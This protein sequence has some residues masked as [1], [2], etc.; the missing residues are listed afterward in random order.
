VIAYAG[1]A[2]SYNAEITPGLLERGIEI[3]EQLGLE[4]EW[5]LSPSYVLG[6]RLARMG[7]TDRARSVLEQFEAQAHERGDEVSRVLALWP[8]ALVEWL[9]GRWQRA[10]GHATAA[11]ELTAQTQHPHAQNWVGR[12]KALIEADLGLVDEARATAEEALSRSRA[13]SIELYTILTEAVLGRVELMLG[14]LEVA[15]DTLRELPER[16]IAGAMNDPTLAVWADAIETL[17]ALGELDRAAAYLEHCSGSAERLNSPL[18]REG[19]L[20]CRGLLTA[21]EGDSD[22]A[23]EAFYQA[24][25]ELPDAPWPFERGRTLLCLG[26]VRRQAQ[27]RK[28]AREAL[29]QAL[30]IFEE[31]G[32][33]LWAEKAR[34]ELRRI[35]GRSPASEELTETERRVAE[36]AARGRTNKQIAA[37]LYMGLSTVESHLSHV[38][39]KLGVRRAELASRLADRED[40]LAK[41]GGGP[42]QS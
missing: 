41:A 6:R 16:L 28:A 40:E 42:V 25:T 37:E 13:S 7:D 18:A 31:L 2:E 21:A 17:V 34:A 23:L 27:Q 29:E 8:L 12:A 10:L 32:A 39:R 20:R 24:F 30:A 1:Q 4:L 22:A 36:L 35:S 9:A 38:Y 5:N 14:N 19:V 26:T 15:G 3:E 11:Y 33:V